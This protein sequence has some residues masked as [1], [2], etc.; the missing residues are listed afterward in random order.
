MPRKTGDKI[1]GRANPISTANYIDYAVKAIKSNKNAK[2]KFS[3]RKE[4]VGAD[5]I[6]LETR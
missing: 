6:Y 1:E 3:D 5:G 4:T 2:S